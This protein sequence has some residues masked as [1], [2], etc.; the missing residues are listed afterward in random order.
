MTTG[1]GKIRLKRFNSANFGFKKMQIEN[2]LYKK[3][4]YFSLSGKAQK[5]KK[6]TNHEWEVVDRKALEAV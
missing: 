5:L 1:E 2:Y 3:D 4:L 6:I